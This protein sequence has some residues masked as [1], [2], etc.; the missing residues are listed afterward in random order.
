[1]SQSV[2][3]R[4]I[5]PLAPYV[6][7]FGAELAALGYTPLS[8]AS[9]VRVMAHLS[10][11]LEG[12]GLGGGD[13][14][15][16]RVE[17]FLAARRAEGYTC[18]LSPRGLGPLL[19]WLRA[20][21]VAPPPPP[22]SA[23]DTPMDRLLADY[24]CW[25]VAERGLG[26]GTVACY[27][28]A[29]RLFLSQCWGA[30]GEPGVQGLS[31]AAV[32]GFV[33]RECAVR[34]AGSAKMLVTGLR[35]LLRF[36]HVAGHVPHSLVGAVPAVAGWR[37]AALPKALA[38]GQV[39]QL[40]ASCDRRTSTGR[41]DFAI[42]L[43]LARLGL[44]AGEVAAVEL[45]DI[46]WRAGDVVVRGK[47]RRVERLPLP[48]DVGEAIA[49]YLRRGRPRETGRVLFLRVRAPRG[50]LGVDGVKAVVRRTCERAGLARVGPHRLRH[51]AATQ[52]LRSGATL[53]EV[54][55]VL[56]H[57]S[58]TTTTIYAK[59]DRGALQ[60]LALPWPGADA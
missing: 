20:S 31:A 16:E 41:R 40:L 9:Q 59:V 60:A 50:A 35:S 47:G 39:G 45:D 15:A 53:G 49:G 11:W 18:R 17:Q 37:G 21:K 54:A 7:G 52:M 4:V 23:A 26:V 51:T 57:R 33:G 36:L 44:R 3:V 38:P 43:L 13:L 12:Q 34:G 25:L 30:G 48:V 27:L 46:D 14:T 19:G 6:D 1:M 5:G 22:P 29:A 56:R 55:Q 42:L 28:A 8:A 24:R 58:L 32:A 10:R 2:S